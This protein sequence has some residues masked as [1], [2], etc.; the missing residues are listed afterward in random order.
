MSV[1]T[2]R[3]LP[4]R[5]LS[6]WAWVT[7]L[8]LG[9]VVVVVALAVRAEQAAQPKPTAS[10]SPS[11]SPSPS[12][13]VAVPDSS[14]TGRRI[15]YSLGQRRVWLVDSGKDAR[16]TFTVW[17][18]SVSPLPGTYT[19]TFRN[20]S[21]TGYDGVP[22]E[23]VVYFSTRS[24]VSIA[25]SNAEDGSSPPPAPGVKT[26]GIRVRVADGDAVWDF[27]TTGTTVSVVD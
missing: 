19:V 20:A 15:V 16:R 26:G 5:R 7:A 14:D 27:G 21:A 25:F 10:A 4:R 9:A 24:G 6:P 11:A 23:N 1:S 2:R 8:T 17:P 12:A 22:I 13:P 3:R 18:G